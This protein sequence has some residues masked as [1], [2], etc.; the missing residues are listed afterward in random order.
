MGGGGRWA[1]RWAWGP[2]PG[3]LEPRSAT[4]W[5]IFTSAWAG[6]R[7]PCAGLRKHTHLNTNSTHTHTSALEAQ[8]LAMLVG[9]E[10][11][12]LR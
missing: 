6:C 1:L 9:R 7:T 4:A 3:C 10:F 8:G 5:P 2:G 11:G 12:R